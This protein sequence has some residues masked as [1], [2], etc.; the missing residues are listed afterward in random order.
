[1]QHQI[2]HGDSADVLK[3]L[4][5]NAL[6]SLV[7]DP[8][9]GIGFMGKA[10]DSDKGGRTAWVASLAAI[11]TE[12]YRVLKPGAHG[13]VWALPRTSHW[14]ATALEDAGFEI[15]DVIVH[16]F[17]TGFP[18]SVDVSKA[19]DKAQGIWRG[20]AG[21]VTI[22]SQPS[23]GREYERTD[24]G[25][26]ATDDAKQWQGWGTALKP[27]TEHWILIRKPIS[28]KTIA[29]NVLAHHTGALNIDGTRISGAVSRPSTNSDIRGGNYKSKAKRSRVPATPTDLGRWPANL[30]L[31]DETLLPNYSRFFY[32]AKPS[33]K[34]K[35]AG[36]EALKKLPG[37]S[38]DLGF[39]KDKLRGYDRNAPKHNNHPTVKPIAL[40]EYLIT[41]ITPPMGTVLDPFAGS[42][43]T[44]VAAKKL[45]F[46]SIGIEEHQPY[47]DIIKARVA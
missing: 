7:T 31:G 28:E 42:G 2:L 21:A 27:A 39:T 10:W 44:M 3:T 13:L 34:E 20:K 19:I 37:G 23:K 14:T 26:P 16:I 11:M 40:M 29:Q 30:I 9:A 1:L 41:L 4:P 8:P 33:T 22:E 25:E 35:N 46:S 45:G 24:K 43:T 17:G 18:K 15:R 12:A 38:T 32:V 47:V 5:S 6:D 36:C